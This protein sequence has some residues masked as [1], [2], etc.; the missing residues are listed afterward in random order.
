MAESQAHQPTKRLCPCTVWQIVTCHAGKENASVSH[1]PGDHLLDG[2]QTKGIEGE[3][4]DEAVQTQWWKWERGKQIEQ[5][6]REGKQ[7]MDRGMPGRRLIL[8]V[9]LQPSVGPMRRTMSRG[10]RPPNIS[11]WRKGFSQ[12]DLINLEVLH[13]NTH[14]CMQANALEKARFIANIERYLAAAKPADL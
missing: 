11:D 6:T 7:R 1:S 10:L 12:S 5:Q 14:V 8:T 4:K 9:C 2:N 3:D 13:S